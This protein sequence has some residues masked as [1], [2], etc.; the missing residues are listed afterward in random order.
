M[1]AF[2]QQAQADLQDVFMNTD[3]HADRVLVEYGGKRRRI[4]VIFEENGEKD[5]TK[6]MRD[7]IDGVFL[8]YQTV[9]I[10]LCD[11][12]VMPE[13]DVH[14]IIAGVQYVIKE[15]GLDVGL[16]TLGLEVYDE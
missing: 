9:F 1:S 2:K 3:E 5:R 12:K 4:P 10:S 14:I 15:T 6:T 8:S 11:M 16:I 13:K 7:N